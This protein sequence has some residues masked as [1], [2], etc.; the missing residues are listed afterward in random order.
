[1]GRYW[2]AVVLLSLMSAFAFLSGCEGTAEAL[3]TGDYLGDP[4]LDDED[5]G[6]RT[7][8]SGGAQL[9]TVTKIVEATNDIPTWTNS[10]L[11]FTGP[12]RSLGTNATDSQWPFEFTY[13]YPP[14]NYQLSDA[15]LLLVTSRDTSDTEAIFVDGVFT[16]RPPSSMVSGVSTKI[17]HRNYSCVGTCSGATAPNGAANTFFMDWALS[18]YKITTE[19][20][21]D[22]NI[23][24]LLTS[25][26][27]AIK[28]LLDDGLFRVVT[29]DDAFV[30]TDT[31]TA[32]RPLLIMTGSTVSSAALS[33]DTS[34]SYKM[35]NNYLY[36]DGNSI[37]Q[38]AFTGSVLTPVNS[39]GSAYTTMRSVEFYYDPRL[40]TLASYDLLNITRADMVIQLRRTN[41]NPTAIVINGI[42]IDQASFDRTPATSAVESW[43]VD[44]ATIAYWNTFVNAIPADVSV[45][46]V[47]LNLVSLLGATTVKELLLQGKLNVSI[48]GPI[49]RIYGQ[50]NTN[51]RTYGVSVNG[52]EL[53]VE[54]NYA[55]EICEVPNNPDSPLNGSGGGP[56]NCLIDTASP[57]I[58]S[59]QVVNITANS[60]RIQWL[61]NEAS[62]TQT[63]HGLV[64][65]STLSPDN[66]SPVS[67]HSVDITGL[68]PYKYYQYNVR[69]TDSCSNQTISSTRSF[70]TLR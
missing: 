7:D 32:S 65:A 62:S 43:S 51:T 25:T 24:S 42:G 27:L 17:I 55:A 44:A 18:H 5:G 11:P 49:T 19:N 30:Q 40:P 64:S 2:S 53:I 48:A 35:K 16:G 46:T 63:A 41:A 14:N 6:T 36:N 1:M 15:R 20:T 10:D 21:F 69:S 37:A 59:V 23:A 66:A 61:T 22:I 8:G 50:A 54:G 47:T 68:S 33:C 34:P 60:A 28:D 3:S 52:P 58:S 39:Y 45:Q 9:Y 57:I 31:A 12:R 26:T 67:F 4:V 29:G 56:I 13:T 70:R 38:P